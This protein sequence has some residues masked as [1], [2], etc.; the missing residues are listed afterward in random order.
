MKS[1]FKQFDI[2]DSKKR[3]RRGLESWCGEN[4][5]T[6][7][8]VSLFKIP[9]EILKIKNVW[10]KYSK[11]DKSGLKNREEKCRKEI[12]FPFFSSQRKINALCKCINIRG[13][14]E[15]F[16]FSFFFIIDASSSDDDS[17]ATL[18]VQKYCKTKDQK[19]YFH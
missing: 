11:R 12:I 4:Q 19:S 8:F 16:F 17:C 15:R 10:K 5:W 13:E 2:R 18:D 9:K 7:L 3:W 14:R 1:F 6:H